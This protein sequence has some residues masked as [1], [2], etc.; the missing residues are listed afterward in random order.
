[1]L[2]GT[3]K[4]ATSVECNDMIEW[5]FQASQRINDYDDS[6]ETNVLEQFNQLNRLKTFRQTVLSQDIEM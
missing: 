4:L 2:E 3:R 6:N 5:A 1:M